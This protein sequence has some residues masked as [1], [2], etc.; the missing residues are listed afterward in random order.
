[1]GPV[2]VGLRSRLAAFIACAR[3]DNEVL[4]RNG[5]ASQAKARGALLTDLEDL[6][7]AEEATFTVDE[8]NKFGPAKETIRR[9]V[10]NG[11]IPDLRHAGRGPMRIRERDVEYLKGK[12]RG[13][14]RKAP[15]GGY[16]PAAHAKK[17]LLG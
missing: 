8:V 10:R 14:R 6:L 12:A 5:A 17:L 9:A 15:P 3:E 1:M 16:D 4:E 7:G 2:D 11:E 13:S